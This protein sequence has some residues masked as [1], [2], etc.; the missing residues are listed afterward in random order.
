MF[1][2]ILLLQMLFSCSTPLN[3]LLLE[4]SSVLTLTTLRMFCAGFLILFSWLWIEKKK[5]IVI[6]KEHLLLFGHKIVF[7][8]YLKYVLK[9]WGLQ[10]ISPTHAAFLFLTTPIWAA[11]YDYMYFNH[12]FTAKQYLGMAITF[13]AIV[14][15]LVCQNATFFPVQQVF[16]LPAIALLCA[17]GAHC[18]G[19]MC[20]KKLITMYS[21]DPVLISA[22]S[23]IGTGFLAFLTILLMKKSFVIGNPYIFVPNLLLL[24][25]IS[26]IIG[27]IWHTYLLKKHSMTM[28]AMAEYLNPLCV[29]LY[30]WLFWGSTVTFLQLLAGVSILLGLYFFHNPKSDVV[31]P[32]V[33]A[34]QV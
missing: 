33:I 20:T 32:A 34:K 28:L 14:P 25:F 9:Y 18:Y 31:V 30:S 15:L 13:F 27:K 21:Y 10:Y 26:N 6:Q 16:C 12:R 5:I 7:G 11:L 22:C 17:V 29:G 19:V 3:K 1:I 24:I 2:D 23:N 8:S 4:Q